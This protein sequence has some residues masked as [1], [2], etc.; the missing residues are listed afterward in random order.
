MSSWHEHVE[1]VNIM[2]YLY[3]YATTWGWYYDHI[4]EA[5]QQR[6]LPDPPTILF[7]FHLMNYGAKMATSRYWLNTSRRQHGRCKAALLKTIYI[8][9]KKTTKNYYQ[10]FM[11]QEDR[12]RVRLARKDDAVIFRFSADSTKIFRILC[13]PVC[14]HIHHH[15]QVQNALFW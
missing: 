9:E 10:L 12:D 6:T 8:R 7:H 2:L 14:E 15:H 3:K 1:H 5:T 13:E 11:T 4:R